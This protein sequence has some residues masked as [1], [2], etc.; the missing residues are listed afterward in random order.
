[1][2]ES[3]IA[4]EYDFLRP[5]AKI[6]DVVFKKVS[7]TRICKT[8]EHEFRMSGAAVVH[9]LDLVKNRMQLSGSDG[10]HLHIFHI[11]GRVELDHVCALLSR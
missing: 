3:G 8:C 2:K 7:I 10:G 1:M 5:Y 6:H 9:P 4:E 11:L